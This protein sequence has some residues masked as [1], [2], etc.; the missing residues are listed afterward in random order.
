MTAAILKTTQNIRKEG[1]AIIN[2]VERRKALGLS[3]TDLATKAGVTQGAIS[4]I[5][6]GIRTPSLDVIIKIAGA[7]GCTVD[8][9]I[10]K[11][12]TV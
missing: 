6:K 9:L 1:C 7:L 4:M 11:E 2:M 8:D 10:G 5:E 12:E 3:Q